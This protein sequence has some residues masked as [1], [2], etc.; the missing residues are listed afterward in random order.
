MLRLFM[1]VKAMTHIMGI[2]RGHYQWDIHRYDMGFNQQYA[3]K[4]YPLVI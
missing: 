4:L 3:I 2:Q 1:E